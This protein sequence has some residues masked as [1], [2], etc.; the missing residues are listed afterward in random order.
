MTHAAVSD[1]VTVSH[2]AVSDTVSSAL[3]PWC[4]TPN[5]KTPVRCQTPTTAAPVPWCQTPTPVASVQQQR[6]RGLFIW[7]FEVLTDI[8]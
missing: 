7:I 1:T 2:A 3:E 6:N 4:L 5:P 8:L